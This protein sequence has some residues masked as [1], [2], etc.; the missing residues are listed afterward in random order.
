MGEARF[1]RTKH[2]KV[3][4]A[5]VLPHADELNTVLD[6][7]VGFLSRFASKFSPP[8]FRVICNSPTCSTDTIVRR[9]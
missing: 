5:K 4:P 1:N 6:F 2:I 9:P 7:G 8:D 3:M